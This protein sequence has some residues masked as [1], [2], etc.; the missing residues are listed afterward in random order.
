MRLS[1]IL[2]LDR[3]TCE[4]AVNREGDEWLYSNANGT[5]P[6][7]VEEWRIGPALHPHKANE[8]YWGG[9][10]GEAIKFIATDETPRA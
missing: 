6:Y 4:P 2:M 9:R 10:V 1:S 7:Q 5:G 3:V 8:R